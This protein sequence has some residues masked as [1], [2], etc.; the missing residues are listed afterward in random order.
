MKKIY[1]LAA[2][3][4]LCSNLFAQI[5]SVDF[6]S[7][8]LNPQSYDNGSAGNGNFMFSSI[9]FSNYYD[10]AWGSWNGFSISNVVD[11]T[12]S[13]FGNQYASYT[14][15]GKNSSNYA[16]F[17]PSGTIEAMGNAL[18]DSFY[19]TNTTFAGISMRDGDAFSK[20]FGS[21]NGAN[22]IPDGTNGED[23]FRVWVI[24]Q[25]YFSQSYDS[26]LIYLADYRNADNSQDYILQDWIKVDVSSMYARTISFRFESSDMGA[27]GINTPTYFALDNLYY[28]L[29]EGVN[30]ISELQISSYPNPFIDQLIVQGE[31]GMLELRDVNGKLLHSEELTGSTIIETASLP[32]G[33]YFLQLTN[34]RGTVLH[35]VIK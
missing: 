5:D 7:F 20:Q 27:W 28:S 9:S 3:A 26:T 25:N 11:N 15:G 2:A 23:F 32:V 13:G 14:G 22:G 6:E 19:I 1:M 16:I 17:Y 12:T 35:K 18:I 30:E 10:V 31:N 29:W 4:M 33:I 21:V 34:D 24:A 8:S